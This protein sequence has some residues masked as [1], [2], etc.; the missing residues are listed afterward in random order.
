M[1]TVFLLLLSSI[2]IVSAQQGGADGS[3]RNIGQDS[4]AYAVHYGF[5]GLRP[6]TAYYLKIR[7]RPPG[8]GNN[9]YGYTYNGASRVWLSQNAAWAEHP[10]ARTNSAGTLGGWAFGRNARHSPAAVDDSLQ[11]VLRL[12]GASSNVNP[13]VKPLVNILDMTSQGGWLFGHVYEDAGFT[14]PCNNFHVLAYRGSEIFGVYTTEKNNV[15]EG[16]DSLNIGYFRI[17]L[18]AGRVDSLQVR[19]H[20]NNRVVTYEKTSPPWT[21]QAGDSTSIDRV[22]VAERAVPVVVRNKIDFFPSPCRQIL[23]I[24][25]LDGRSYRVTVYNAC[26]RIVRRLPEGARVFHRQALASGVYFFEFK[27]G[28]TQEVFSVAFVD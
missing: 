25:A 21:I 10:L 17:A 5:T 27:A 12:Y 6:D 15:L 23:R 28:D 26:G 24:V 7:L 9:Y 2:V 11:I 4:T 16:Y 18:S 19:D 20:N 1:R 22:G 13:T 3:P 14:R 8:G